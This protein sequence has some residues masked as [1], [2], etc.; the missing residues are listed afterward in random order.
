MAADITQDRR[1]RAK[2]AQ[3]WEANK[4]CIAGEQAATGLNLYQSSYAFNLAHMTFWPLLELIPER[5]QLEFKTLF[6]DVFRTYVAWTW[7]AWF[8][9][10]WLH[11][12]QGT[13]LLGLEEETRLRAHILES[14]RDFPI[15]PN[16]KDHPTDAEQQP[17][18]IDPLSESFDDLLAQ[19]PFLTDVWDPDPKALEPFPLPK[20]C[21]RNFLWQDDPNKVDCGGK[22]LR[23]VFP[24][25][26]YLCVYWFGRTLGV[27]AP[28]R[29]RVLVGGY[30][31]VGNGY[32]APMLI[33]PTASAN[34]DGA[35]MTR[36]GDLHSLAL[37]P[38]LPVGT[39]LLGV[40][41]D[42]TVAWPCLTVGEEPASP[43]ETCL[44]RASKRLKRQVASR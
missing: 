22:N 24:G 29:P 19:F 23:E 9:L 42:G 21:A 31:P 26:D 39:S 4:R 10:M 34:L 38:E 35:A 6:R 15:A 2:F 17:Y 16:V 43:R 40:S 25:I 11:T 7:N 18:T 8:D 13:P 36:R 1:Y 12:A 20:R 37:P 32:E 14:L 30:I 5:D 27:I 44:R 41:I 33:N 3:A 28:P